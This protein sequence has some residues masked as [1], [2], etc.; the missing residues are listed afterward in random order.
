MVPS[1]RLVIVAQDQR[2]AAVVQS[3]LQRAIQLNAPVVRYE[4]VP[5]LLTPETDGD[6]LLVASDPADAH[7]VEAVVRETKVQHLPAGLSVLET[8]A[9]RASGKLDSLNPYIGDRFVWPHHPRELTA[10]AHRALAPGTPF[11]DP[12]TE[13]VSETIRRRLINHT[14]SLTAMVEL[15]PCGYKV[16]E[17]AHGAAPASSGFHDVCTV[18]SDRFG[19]SS[20]RAADGTDLLA[21]PI[22]LAVIRD[23]S[24]AFGHGVSEFYLSRF[25]E[26]MGRP[27]FVSSV[28]VDDGPVI[29]IT[30][31][32]ARWQSSEIVMDIVQYAGTDAIELRFAIDWAER[33][34]MLKLEIPV[35]LAQPKNFAK[36]PAAVIQR[37]GD[38]TEQPYQDSSASLMTSKRFSTS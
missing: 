10:W 27:T 19:L 31:Q 5:Q 13:S 20:L 3:H 36:V 25:R 24:S 2:L 37:A 34:Q 8:D 23:P 18:S 35:G 9:V 15:P 1:R 16:L 38:G 30:R 17:L 14:P 22:G 28:V 33:G 12:A 32:R 7:L 11:A 4:D 6:L 26:E 21:A 29:K